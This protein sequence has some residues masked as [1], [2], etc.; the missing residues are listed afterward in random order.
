LR[1]IVFLA[2]DVVDK[3]LWHSQRVGAK[4]LAPLIAMNIYRHP[5]AAIFFVGFVVYIA[6]RAVYARRLRGVE[7]VHRQV[8]R[9]ETSLLLI[10]IPSGLLL[11]V[12]YL[13]TPLLWFA[14]Y[15]LPSFVPWC[16]VVLMPVALWLFWRS[17]VDLGTNWSATLE[18]RKAHRVVTHGVYRYIRHPMYAAILLWGL[19]QAMLLPNWLAGWSAFVP[20]TVLYLVRT[21]REEQMMCSIFGDEYREYMRKTGRLL[22]R[23]S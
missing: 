21:P 10:V 2:A 6:I 15:R 12:L 23:L 1:L 19:A 7:S 22:P 16:G 13:F 14:D 9:L 11:P 4:L 20:F 8:D 18:V 5:S 17:H 3:R